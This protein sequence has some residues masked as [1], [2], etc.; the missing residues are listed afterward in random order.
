MSLADEVVVVGPCAAGKSTLVAG[1][2]R[3]GVGARAVAQEHSAVP[4]LYRLRPCL[5]V[6]FLAADWPT[7]HA[8]R[9]LSAGRAQWQEELLRLTEAR[10]AA[11]LVVHTDGLGIDAVRDVVYQWWESLRR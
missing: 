10:R 5:A 11:R 9:P 7:V 3:L 6:V 2:K 8:R 1:L 4:H